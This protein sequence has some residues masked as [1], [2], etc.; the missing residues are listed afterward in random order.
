MQEWGLDLNNPDSWIQTLLELEWITPD[1]RQ[2][3]KYRAGLMGEPTATMDHTEAVQA[4]FNLCP[5]FIS[6]YFDDGMTGGVKAAVDTADRAVA[7]IMQ[8]IG[9]KGSMLKFERA[10]ANATIST[11]LRQPRQLHEPKEAHPEPEFTP[12]APGHIDVLGKIIDIKNQLRYDKADR[13]GAFYALLRAILHQ[14]KSN[15]EHKASEAALMRA[16]GQACYVTDT[17]TPLRAH[18]TSMIAALTKASAWSAKTGSHGDKRNQ[19]ASMGKAAHDIFLAYQTRLEASNTDAFSEAEHEAIFAKWQNL[20]LGRQI[21]LPQEAHEQFENLI[22]G[23][24][25]F[26]AECL[27]PMRSSPGEDAIWIMNDS[28]G[29][30]G[31]LDDSQRRA[32]ACWYYCKSWA[33]IR[34]TQE[35]WLNQVLAETHSSSQELSNGNANLQYAIMMA[36]KE[37]DTWRT[38]CYIEVY[39]SLAT[40]SVLTKMG[41]KTTAMRALVAERL[42]MVQLIDARILTFWQARGLGQPADDFSKFFNNKAKQDLVDRYQ[43]PVERLP[44][45]RVRAGCVNSLNSARSS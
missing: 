1:I 18:T 9:I 3:I 41:A 32:G 30:S 25:N 27:M 21:H 39:D 36:Q 45:R 12:P 15:P 4:F 14:A 38:S 31:E 17:C 44:E 2:W 19:A 40:T 16:L 11:R 6:G 13:L 5:L 29:L 34:W 33:T 37:P 24:Q 23:L 8:T 28:A 26:N 42:E 43:V 10:Y 7:Y 35:L 20:D 22:L